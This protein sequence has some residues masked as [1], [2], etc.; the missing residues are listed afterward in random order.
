[1]QM[2]RKIGGEVLFE[3]RSHVTA[4]SRIEI[5]PDEG[6][7]PVIG[8]IRLVMGARDTALMDR[9]GVWDVELFNPNDLDEVY[10]LAGG[11]FV[12]DKQ[13]TVGAEELV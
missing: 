8:A 12:I 2:R 4:S 5:E 7:G 1:M 10:R 13:V 3:L 9:G 11:D 6:A